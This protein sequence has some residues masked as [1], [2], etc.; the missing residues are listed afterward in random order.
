[1]ENLPLYYLKGNLIVA[2]TGIDEES[3]EMW[4]WADEHTCLWKYLAQIGSFFKDLKI[5]A[6]HVGTV[7]ITQKPKFRDIYFDG[8]GLVFSCSKDIWTLR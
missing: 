1:M 6:G 2:H 5:I 8:E 7:K 4:E 3:E